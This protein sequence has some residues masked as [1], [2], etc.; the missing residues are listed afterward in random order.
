[1]ALVTLQ[2]SLDMSS[3][4]AWYGDVLIA[5][6]SQI[7]LSDGYRVQD[8]FGSFQYDSYGLSGGYVTSTVAYAGNVRV[9]EASGFNVNAVTLESYIDYD[10][11]AALALVLSGNDEIRGSN[12]ADVLLGYAGNDRLYGNGG[13]DLFVGDPGSDWMDGGAGLDVAYYASAAYAYS[14]FNNGGF[15]VSDNAGNIDTLVSVERLVFGDGKVLALDIGFGQSAGAA[16]R[17]Y[18]AAFDRTPDRE[19]LAFWVGQLDA[20]ST[21]FQVAQG[22]VE[23]PEFRSLYPDRSNEAVLNNYYL[24]VLDRPADADGF[25][26]WNDQMSKGLPASEV[27]VWFA[28]SPENIANTNAAVQSGIWLV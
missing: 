13:N 1:M 16:Y 17:L 21:L 7:R 26:Y 9:F 22:F 10:A 2:Q 15:K 11:Q 5:N 27:L 25:A 6:G 20:G 19:G 14:V 24:N 3:L 4:Y 12:G 18:Q 8:Y 28:E 23:S